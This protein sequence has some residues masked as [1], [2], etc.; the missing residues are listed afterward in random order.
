MSRNELANS[1]LTNSKTKYYFQDV[2]IVNNQRYNKRN[3]RKYNDERNIISKVRLNR[4]C[5]YLCFC[6]AR[7]RKITDNILIDEGMDL[8]SRRLDIFNIF[9][10]IYKAEQRNE[11]LLNEIVTMSDDCI[12]RLNFERF[13]TNGSK[14]DKS[15]NSSY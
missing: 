2:E 6:F 10:K 9:E 15:S 1:N 3:N 7:R 4:A 12:R 5:I 14:S 13:N 8:I 11:P